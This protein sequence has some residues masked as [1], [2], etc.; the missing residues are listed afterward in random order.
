MVTCGLFITNDLQVM[1]QWSGMVVQDKGRP[2]RP[3]LA[4]HLVKRG[5]GES[6]NSLTRD[7][8]KGYPLSPVII[9]KKYI[10]G[11]EV[12]NRHFSAI[13]SR[14]NKTETNFYSHKKLN[15]RIRKYDKKDK[16]IT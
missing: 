1:L 7:Q 16:F 9:N 13:S 2:S 15:L 8:T 5:G 14:V 10:I 3:R 4:F 12:V 6:I 11:Y